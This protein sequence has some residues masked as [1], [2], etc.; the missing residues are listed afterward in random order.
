[1]ERQNFLEKIFRVIGNDDQALLQ[2]ENE[3]D[4]PGE[5]R[6]RAPSTTQPRGAPRHNSQNRFPPDR[7]LQVCK[8]IICAPLYNVSDN[9]YAGKL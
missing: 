8:S 5:V 7:G 1:M 4:T 9:Q 2:I 6:P 3:S